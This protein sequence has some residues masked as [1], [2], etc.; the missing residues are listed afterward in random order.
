MFKIHPQ[1]NYSLFFDGGKK[2]DYITYGYVIYHKDK[3]IYEG[4]G[5]IKSK[6]SS[7]VAE[8]T[9]LIIGLN[10][11]IFFG[12][13]NIQCFGD[14][15]LVINQINGKF[16][17]KRF[18]SFHLIIEQLKQKFDNFEIHWISRKYN[19]RADRQTRQI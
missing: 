10:V 15:Q 14:S 18:K 11:A 2:G 19:S 5:K 17:N 12:I 6:L 16:K 8:Y 1:E 3:V 7:N 9:S 4:G 13:K